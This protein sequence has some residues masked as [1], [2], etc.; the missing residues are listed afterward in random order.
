M[1]TTRPECLVGHVVLDI[2][3]YRLDERLL[4]LPMQDIFQRISGDLAGLEGCYLYFDKRKY[5]WIRSG[6][7]SGDGRDACFRGRGKKHEANATC[8]DQ[9]RVHRLYREYPDS[10]VENLGAPEGN[11]DNLVMYCGM[12]YDKKMD[13]TPLRSRDATGS[14]FVWSDEVISELTKKGGDL[15]KFQLDAVAYLWEICYDLLLAKT[16]NVSMSPGFESLGLRV[17]NDNDKKRKRN[18]D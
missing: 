2:E 4:V 1:M 17:N 13:T 9:M 16:D 8:K 11:F 6:K 3:L 7:T 15:K 14:L 5:K 18:A 10:G 12:A